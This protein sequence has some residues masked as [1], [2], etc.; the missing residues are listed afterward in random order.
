MQP[1][2]NADLHET[3]S[4]V[5]WRDENGIICS[6]SKKAPPATIEQSKKDLEAF[7]KKF[8]EGKFCM[9]LDITNWNRH[10]RIWLLF[11]NHS[12]RKLHLT[13]RLYWV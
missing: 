4:S 8:G 13:I 7:Q 12:T 2:Q 11:F 9:L 5:A 1:P 10:K 3:T 6:I